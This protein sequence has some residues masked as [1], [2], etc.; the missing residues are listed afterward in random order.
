[1]VKSNLL[2]VQFRGTE[3]GVS[4]PSELPTASECLQ[5]KR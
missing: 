1:M 4:I 2:I 3:V 5:V